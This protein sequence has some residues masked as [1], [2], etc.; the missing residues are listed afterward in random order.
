MQQRDKNSYQ[1]QG[2]GEKAAAQEDSPV[3][4]VDLKESLKLAEGRNIFSLSPPEK[5][6]PAPAK[7][8]MDIS[9]LLE[10]LKVVAIIWAGEGSQVMVED[11]KKE[12][13]YSLIKGDVINNFRVKR[14]NKNFVI[15]ERDGKEWMIR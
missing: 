6:V 9:A 3:L 2:K 11:M 8:T 13:S 15:L 1:K 5:E 7:A 10:D 12:K 4:D 14:I